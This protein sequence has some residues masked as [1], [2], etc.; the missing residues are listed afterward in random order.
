MFP[1]LVWIGGL[2]RVMRAAGRL[3]ADSGSRSHSVVTLTLNA[4]GDPGIR[5]G[6]A[7]PCEPLDG[8]LVV[9]RA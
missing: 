3:L 1:I 6:V 8:Q 2:R 9:A 4:D 7:A 5:L